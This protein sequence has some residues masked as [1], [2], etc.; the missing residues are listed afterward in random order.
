VILDRY[1]A[2]RYLLVLLGVLLTFVAIFVIVDLFDNIDT[3]IDKEASAGTIARL[4]LSEVPYIVQIILP[5]SVLIAC[6]FGIGGLASS[7]EIDAMRASGRSLIR[8]LMP[9]FICGLAIAGSATWLATSVVPRTERE[10]RNIKEIDIRGRPRI[11][12]QSRLNLSYSG[13]DGHHYFMRRW[14]GR[15][16]QM[17]G[18]EIIHTDAAGQVREHLRAERG[19]WIDGAWE[20]E[21]GVMREFQDGE[22]QGFSEFHTLR[23]PDLPERPEDFST[24]K[25]K[26]RE[27]TLGELRKR[28]EVQRRSGEPTYLEA[29]N[30]Q[31]R[32]A[33]PLSSFVLILL[34]APLS[35]RRIR[36]G[37]WIGFI[38]Y[39]LVGFLFFGLIRFFQ[40]LG[41]HGSLSPWVAAWAP[42]LAFAVLGSAVLLWRQRGY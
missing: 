27:L 35:A 14:D 10:A 8:I 40:T 25:R 34:G 22:E 33:F 32:F 7:G 3:Y 20:F 6:F 18:V 42:D 24:E 31:I 2:R 17:E 38:I 28:L 19:R 1:V 16:K 15:R 12:Y 36:S 5:I 21:G 29:T 4:Y 39:V 23:R 11:D 13:I 41:E 30:L 37:A 26:T 9:V